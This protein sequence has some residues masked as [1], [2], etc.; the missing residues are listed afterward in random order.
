L[1]KNALRASFLKHFMS[2][3]PTTVE[4]VSTG[5]D[6]AK[7]V[8]AALLL[9]GSVAA[10]VGMAAS[11]APGLGIRPRPDVLGSPVLAIE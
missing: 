2:S 1:T 4:T 6:K 7:L 8:G 10:L 11:T 9:V 3:N 5:A